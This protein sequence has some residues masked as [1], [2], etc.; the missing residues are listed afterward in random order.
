MTRPLEGVKC[1]A[2]I[3][4]EQLTVALSMMADLGA[5]VI[6]IEPPEGELGRQLLAVPD[7]PFSPYFETNNRGFKCI[8]LD[9][10]TEKAREILYK[11]VKDAD[12]FAQN[13]RPGV[14]QR[15]GCGYDDLV[16][17]NP[18]IVYLS[19]SAYGPDGPKAM[20]PG[21][22]GVAQAMGGIGSAFGQEGTPMA[23]GQ[24][25]VGDETA[26]F[27]NFQ[28]I[29][30]GLY[31][32]M[33]TGEGQ[34]IETSLFGSQIRLMGFFMTQVLI[35]GKQMPRSRVRMVVG[36]A[37]N[38]TASFNDKDGKPFMLQVVGEERWRKGLEATGFA[39]K[40]DEV[41]CG[42]LVEVAN[43]PEKKKIFLDT[44]DEQFAT[45]TREHWLELLRGADV[46]SAPINTLAEAGADPDAI[47]NN[48]VIEVDH[49]KWGKIKE[50]G[51]PW[52]FHK[53]PAKAGLAPELGEHNDEVLKGLGFSDADI[54]QLKE[55]RVI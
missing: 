30:V 55:E 10:K 48:Y 25:A 37:P 4:F 17:I 29:M 44:M 51:F 28:A 22:D 18:G 15:L 47:A 13:F 38:M 43:S 11:L 19:S 54:K 6:K 46:I 53:T 27:H 7:L 20:L 16:K 8:T 26:A 36:A 52:K 2:V 31:H 34:L 24:V 23:T 9:L 12:V 3:M 5:E 49:P 40:L 14:A 32:K 39:T 50:V 45:D 33:K 1:V 41:G 42:S 35:T 21:T